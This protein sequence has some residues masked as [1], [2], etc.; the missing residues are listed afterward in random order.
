MTAVLITVITSTHRTHETNVKKS[1]SALAVI[2]AEGKPL[3]RGS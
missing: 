1:Y 2:N 3:M